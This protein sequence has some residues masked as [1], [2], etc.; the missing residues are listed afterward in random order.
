MMGGCAVNSFTAFDSLGN[1]LDSC[2][3]SDKLQRSSSYISPTG[4]KFSVF[5][6]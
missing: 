1:S 5:D 2:S 3:G 4:N 6:F